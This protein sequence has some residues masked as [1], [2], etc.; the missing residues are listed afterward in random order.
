MDVVP[1][2]V[3][4][5]DLIKM[6]PAF[7]GVT[8]AHTYLPPFFLLFNHVL[9]DHKLP[10][11]RSYLFLLL[12]RQQLSFLAAACPFPSLGSP[13]CGCCF[14]PPPPW[15]THVLPVLASQDCL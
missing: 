15:E 11:T 7:C 4:H 6:C 9:N 14:I 1:Q 10:E 2:D 8:S 5:D 12:K 3:Q 13:S